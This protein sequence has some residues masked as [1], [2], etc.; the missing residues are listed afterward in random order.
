MKSDLYT[1]TADQSG[2]TVWQGA[3]PVSFFP[4]DGDKFLDYHTG[5][6]F[7]RVA[8]QDAPAKPTGSE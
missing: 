1:F 5:C 3:R 6:W 7:P 8:P 4:R 2:E